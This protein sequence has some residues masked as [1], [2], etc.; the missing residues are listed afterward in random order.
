[1]K[2]YTK[3]GIY[4]MKEIELGISRGYLFK[5]EFKK[6]G[7]PYVLYNYGHTDLTQFEIM[8]YN[9]HHNLV[10][11][12]PKW[13]DENGVL[14]CRPGYGKQKL[15]TRASIL[16]EEYGYEA[17]AMYRL[18]VAVFGRRCIWLDDINEPIHLP[19]KVWFYPEWMTGVF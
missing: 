9:I 15:I 12:G 11:W 8:C 14:R 4:N 19:A 10:P 18:Y 7:D 16:E 1:M 2:F 17:A 13:V 3:E 5:S 6:I